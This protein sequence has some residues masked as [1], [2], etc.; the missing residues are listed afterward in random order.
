MTALTQQRILAAAV[1]LLLSPWFPLPGLAD[2]EKTDAAPITAEEIWKSPQ[3]RRFVAAGSGP[4]Y[5]STLQVPVEAPT[6]M[7][8]GTSGALATHAGVGTLKAGGSATDAAITTALVQTVLTGGSAVSFAGVWTLVYYE[9]DTGELHSLYAGYNTVQDERDPMSIPH[10]DYSEPSG[11]SFSE[12]MRALK[13]SGRTALV[14]GF[15]AGVEATHRRFGKLPWATLFEPAI[16]LA[17]IGI[18]VDDYLHSVIAANDY[19]LSRLPA[20]KQVFTRPDGRFYRRGDIFAQP[21]LAETLEQVAAQ[22]AR[23]MYSGP[24]AK[25]MVAAVRADGG[26]ITMKD[27]QDY[28][29]SWSEP[30]R[31]AYKDFEIYALAEPAWGGTHIVEGLN[32][33]ELA[34]LGRMAEHHHDSGQAMYWFG[35]ISQLKNL[36]YFSPEYRSFLY[37]GIDLSLAARRSKETSSWIWNEMQRTN[38]NFFKLENGNARLDSSPGHSAGIVAVDQWG[39][40]AAVLHT[41]N[42]LHFGRTGIFV[43][44]V[45]IPDSARLQRQQ[46]LRAG[47][48]NPVPGARNPLIVMKD[49]KPFLG[50]SAIGAS[51]H[52]QTLQGLYYVLEKGMTPNEAAGSPT[53]LGSGYRDGKFSAARG[54]FSSRVIR[55]LEAL[56][57]TF[58]PEARRSRFWVSIMMDPKSG[59]LVSTDAG[60]KPERQPAQPIGLVEGY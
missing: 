8:T 30:A 4:A 35:Q 40:M 28:E 26:R 22:G 55:E 51:L 20:T 2:D 45:S 34:D 5:Q 56:G 42:T 6:A 16:Y 37:P 41:I 32:L 59:M 49:N 36:S 24:W 13:P 29:V 18:P 53:F 17:R 7:V 9:A 47:P 14:P 44:G 19:V 31:G 43:D 48:G 10:I 54:E 57:Q 23:Y 39:N 15:M 50:S 3:M 12:Q 21:A 1:V 27:L 11:L 52:E 33:L 38:G 25:K 60:V 46:I 58:S